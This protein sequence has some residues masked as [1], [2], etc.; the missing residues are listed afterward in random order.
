MWD[1]ASE[2]PVLKA[3]CEMKVSKPFAIDFYQWC[4][5]ICSKELLLDKMQVGETGSIVEIDETSL[6]KKS[7]FNRWTRHQDFWLFGRVDR[8]ASKWFARFVYDDRTKP[9]LSDVIEQHI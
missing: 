1:W 5:G 9:T 4:R 8:T 6:K 3:K 2:K 7:K